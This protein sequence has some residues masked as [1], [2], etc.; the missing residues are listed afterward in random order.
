MTP[1]V[2]NEVVFIILS[3]SAIEARHPWLMREFEL[4]AI[5]THPLALKSVAA[6]QASG[7]LCLF[8]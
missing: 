8:T 7:R 5:I 4:Y 3:L 1:I 6:C 2:Y